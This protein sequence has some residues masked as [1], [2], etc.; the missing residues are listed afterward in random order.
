MTGIIM[1][2]QQQMWLLKSE[3]F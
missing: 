3:G 1:R 2:L